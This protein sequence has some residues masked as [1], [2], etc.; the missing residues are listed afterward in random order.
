MTMKTSPESLSSRIFDRLQLS[1]ICEKSRKEGKTIVFTN[2]CFDL[3]HPGHID[4]LSRASALGDMLVIGVNTD[5]SVRRL[6]K[7]LARP[8][9]SEQDRM[10]IL[11]SLRFVDAVVLFDEDTPLELIKSLRPHIIVKGGDYTESTVVG[12]DVVKSYGG[13]VVILP[14][15]QGYSTTD[16]ERK[17]KNS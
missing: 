12:A 10:L 14:F 11:A 16:I 3:I 1:L 6:N 17:I 5:D 2:G 13:K 7:G 8:L 4:Y 9:Q 15:L